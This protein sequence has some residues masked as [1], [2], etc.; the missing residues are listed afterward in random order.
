[1]TQP[2]RRPVPESEPEDTSGRRGCVVAG[3]V[4]GI[5][6]GILFAFFLMPPLLHH[7]FG[8]TDVRVGAGYSAGGKMIGVVAVRA[9]GGEGYEVQLQ[10]STTHTWTPAPDDFQLEFSGQSVRVTA[11]PPSDSLPE[12]DLAFPSGADRLLVLRFP[13]IQAGQPIALHLSNPRVRF[14]L[15]PASQP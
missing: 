9:I 6:A 5:V 3:G 12:S 8:E 4:L 14:L 11:E 15:P 1:M 13:V 7:Y 2:V 10:V